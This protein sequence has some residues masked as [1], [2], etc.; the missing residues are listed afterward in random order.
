M[1][2]NIFKILKDRTEKVGHPYI[3]KTHRERCL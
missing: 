1:N 2:V 3:R